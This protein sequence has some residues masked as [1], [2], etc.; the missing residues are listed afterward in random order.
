MVE[1][2]AMAEAWECTVDSKTCTDNLA[3][4]QSSNNNLTSEENYNQ[5]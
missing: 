1:A 5:L 4:H 2:W 3:K